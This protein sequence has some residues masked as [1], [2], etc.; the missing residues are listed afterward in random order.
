VGEGYEALY[1]V[2]SSYEHDQELERE[3]GNPVGVADA[4]N[5]LHDAGLIH[6]TSDGFVFVTRAAARF[7]QLAS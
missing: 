4:I 2:N 6:R 5:A 7:S 3:V 1:L